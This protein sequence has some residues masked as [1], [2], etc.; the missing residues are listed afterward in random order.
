[1]TRPNSSHT[2]KRR[3]NRQR[4]RRTTPPRLTAE[5]RSA[6]E[7]S[8]G[9]AFRDPSLLDRAMTHS[10]SVPGDAALWSNERLE[11][12][13]DRVLG[14]VISEELI[15][16]FEAEREGGLAPRLNGLVNKSACADVAELFGLGE[17]VIMDVADKTDGA[18]ARMSILAD[19]MEAVIGAL[20]LD[21]GLVAAS[22]LIVRGWKSA[23]KGM[24]EAP[25]DPKSQLQEILQGKGRPAPLYQAVGKDGPDHAPVFRVTVIVDGEEAAIGEGRSKQEAERDAARTLLKTMGVSA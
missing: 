11:F 7:A 15:R 21:Q 19:A 9:V 3:R 2:G 13:G 23:F 17:Y 12:L 5:A 16:R 25:L 4:P 14:L 22:D 1:M 18:A 8:L 6:L 20:Y 10:S 24:A